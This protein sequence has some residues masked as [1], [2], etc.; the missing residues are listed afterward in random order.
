V[1]EVAFFLV[2]PVVSVLTLE[3]VRAVR[4]WPVGDEGDASFDGPGAPR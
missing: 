2:V 3:A 1:E 4:R